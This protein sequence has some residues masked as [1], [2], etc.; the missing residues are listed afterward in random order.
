[1]GRPIDNTHLLILDAHRRIVPIGVPG[2]LYI[3]GAGVAKGYLNRPEL[4]AE[5][6]IPLS[7]NRYPATVIRQ[8]TT[9]LG[10]RTSDFGPRTSDLGLRTIVYRTGDLVRCRED[11]EIEFLGR[12]DTQVKIR[13]FRIEPGEIEVAL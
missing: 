13:G 9:D 11:G 6:F 2:E 8:P 5:R 10:L 4:T 12:I 7:G 3:G 1:I